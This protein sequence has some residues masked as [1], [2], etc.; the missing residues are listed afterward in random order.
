MFE[1][2]SMFNFISSIFS[3]SS[4]LIFLFIFFIVIKGIS[5]QQDISK[6]IDEVTD[7]SLDKEKEQVE[8]DN[9]EYKIM[10]CPN[11][12]ASLDDNLKVCNYCGSK[13]IKVKR[14]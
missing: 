2:N 14:K 13:L 8:E 6:K 4:I 10:K 3:V 12:G 9:Y 7:L 5:H 1:F 11:C